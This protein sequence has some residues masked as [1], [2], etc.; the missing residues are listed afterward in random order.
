MVFEVFIID[1]LYI[2]W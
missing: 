1:L 2:N